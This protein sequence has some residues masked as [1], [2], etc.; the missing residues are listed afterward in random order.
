MEGQNR[1]SSSDE[2]LELFWDPRVLM[3]F[4]FDAVSQA[5][6]TYYRSA[7]FLSFLQHGLRTFNAPESP[8]EATTDRQTLI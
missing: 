7:A 3:K 5:M 1:E 2:R 8:P 6:E 4:W